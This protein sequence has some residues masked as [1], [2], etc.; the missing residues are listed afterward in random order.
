MF[1][2][3][4]SSVDLLTLSVGRVALIIMYLDVYVFDV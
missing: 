3:Y 4:V 1:A 2:G